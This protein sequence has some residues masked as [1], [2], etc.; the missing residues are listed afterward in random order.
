MVP[1][2]AW[3]L[4]PDLPPPR[5]TDSECCKDG[6]CLNF[7]FLMLSKGVGNPILLMLNS[8]WLHRPAP[9][10]LIRLAE[11]GEVVQPSSNF[12]RV[13]MAL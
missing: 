9:R 12:A 3:M 8:T 10:Q 4:Q 6:G 7:S 2:A 1:G 5:L 11:A 13:C